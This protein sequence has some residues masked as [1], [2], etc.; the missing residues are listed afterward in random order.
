MTPAEIIAALDRDLQ[1]EG[2]DVVFRR[3]VPNQPTGIEAGARAHVSGYKPTELPGGVTVGAR[4]AIISPTSFKGTAFE[5]EQNWPQPGDKLLVSGRQCH[6]A[7]ADNK[8]RGG[9]LVRIV[10]TVT[11]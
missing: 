11:G 9:Q 10:L 5:A 2:Q 4:R 8:V 7:A 1:I 3:S 6:V